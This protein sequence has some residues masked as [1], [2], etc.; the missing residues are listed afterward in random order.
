VAY[1]CWLKSS[2]AVTFIEV[3]F[4]PFSPLF[5]FEIRKNK[6]NLDEIFFSSSCVPSV[7]NTEDTCTENVDHTAIS[8]QTEKS[9]YWNFVHAEISF[10]TK[11]K[12]KAD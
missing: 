5:A 6:T 12:L 2:Q 1:R 7:N 4:Q 10:Q 3:S 11:K 8:F 9:F